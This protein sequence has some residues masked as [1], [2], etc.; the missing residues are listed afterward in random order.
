MTRALPAPLKKKL[1]SR[2][3]MALMIF[4]ILT[5]RIKIYFDQ[6]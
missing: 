3:I 5:I 1:F 6:K 4:P 2:K